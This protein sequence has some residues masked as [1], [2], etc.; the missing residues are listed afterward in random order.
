MELH[1]IQ[2][3]LEL[4]GI[5]TAIDLGEHRFCELESNCPLA[6]QMRQVVTQ[7]GIGLADLLAGI[8]AVQRPNAPITLDTDAHITGKATISILGKTMEVDIADLVDSQ[9]KIKL[10]EKMDDI[11]DAQQHLKRLGNS[12]Y[13]T[14]IREIDRLR[15]TKVLPQ[16]RPSIADT[17]KYGAM[18]TTSTDG[19]R[20][21]FLFNTIY[22]PEWV[23]DNGVRYE[24]SP[25]DKAKIRKDA[26][27][28]I[29]VLPD[30]KVYTV[31]VLDD[32][33]NKFNHYHGGGG[34]TDDCWGHGVQPFANNHST[35][36]ASINNIKRIALGM[37]ATI[38][39]NSLANHN[40]PY[41]GWPTA[42][43]LRGRATAEGREGDRK[44]EV[45]PDGVGWRAGATP[46]PAR[47]ARLH[48]EIMPPFREDDMAQPAVP[49]T[50]PGWGAGR[51]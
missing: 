44:D 23:V 42:Q 6:I 47:R 18:I 45:A 49:Q 4:K 50:R 26:V 11:E 21:A 25:A 29:E 2:K 1:E 33:G 9:V 17:I 24:L 43:E 51:R 34:R 35:A 15:E 19:N 10:K 30:G 46:A 31:Y 3:A 22:A 16:L 28:K 32:E 14:Y 8:D 36:V 37:L 27:L 40:S 20:Y 7:S 12:L 48:P 39:M 38:N 13:N 5:V 41:P